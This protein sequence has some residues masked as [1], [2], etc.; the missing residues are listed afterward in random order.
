MIKLRA[1]A[2]GGQLYARSGQFLTYILLRNSLAVKGPRKKLR[3]VA[4]PPPESG[5]TFQHI[6]VLQMLLKSQCA[7]YKVKYFKHGN[8][9]TYGLAWR[10]R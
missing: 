9:H 8:E 7:H 1:K 4:D 6:T 5:E 3:T 10:K 2:F